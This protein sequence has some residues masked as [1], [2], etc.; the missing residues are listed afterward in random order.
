MK[1]NDRNKRQDNQSEQINQQRWVVRQMRFRMENRKSRN[2]D[3]V[4]AD[5]EHICAWST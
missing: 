4:E 3:D 2:D 1:Q 5:V